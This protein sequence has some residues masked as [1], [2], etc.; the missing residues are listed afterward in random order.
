MG[1]SKQPQESGH[2]RL[3]LSIEHGSFRAIGTHIANEPTGSIARSEFTNP[4]L[5]RIAI[6]AV[7][8]EQSDA[9]A[10]LLFPMKRIEK[11]YSNRRIISVRIAI[12]FPAN[13]NGIND[14]GFLP[15]A[16]RD[17]F[18]LPRPRDV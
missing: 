8:I 13:I 11:A 2:S 5:N 16:K 4:R 12:A 18:M 3:E 10:A 1:Q 7:V 9:L 6:T 15:T 14:R 17:R